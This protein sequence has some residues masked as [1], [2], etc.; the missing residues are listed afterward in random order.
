MTAF[1][2][3][4]TLTFKRGDTWAA[5]FYCYDDADNVRHVVVVDPAAELP[6]GVRVNLTGTTARL[7]VRHPRLLDR[8]YAAEL[9][10]G[11]TALDN[12]GLIYLAAPPSATDLIPA[13]PYLTDLELTF[14]SGV[15]LSSESYKLK[16][17]QDYTF[18]DRGAAVSPQLDVVE[19]PD[20]SLLDDNLMLVSKDGA[21]VAQAYPSAAS[22]DYGLIT[23][24][25]GTLL[26][27]GSIA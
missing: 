18:D 16:I 13:G 4:P 23:A 14:P 11:L 27:Y 20:P 9:G 15:V 3:T 24:A 5:T 26:D 22:T 7:H 17:T 6:A 12:A 19:I 21:W 25:A 8:L 10:A 1:T 2:I